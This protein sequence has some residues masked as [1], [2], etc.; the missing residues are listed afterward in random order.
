VIIDFFVVKRLHH[1]IHWS[2]TI[3]DASI[4][5]NFSIYNSNKY[6]CTECWFIAFILSRASLTSLRGYL[7]L[8][9][10]WSN[11][12]ICQKF[13]L[14]YTPSYIFPLDYDYVLHIFNFHISYLFYI[15]PHVYTSSEL[16][17]DLLSELLVDFYF[18]FRYQKLSV[19]F[20][21]ELEDTTLN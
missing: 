16:L 13:V 20:R 18:I 1:P 6:M 14:P 19:T 2:I 8:Y 3:I 11:L 21:H 10:T 7:L 12:Y 5:F 15:I 17:E 4:I 9:G